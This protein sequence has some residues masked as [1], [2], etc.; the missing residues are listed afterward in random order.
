MDAERQRG[1]AVSRIAAAISEPARASMLY[2]LMDNRARTSTELAVIASVSPS[3]ASAHLNRLKA[4]RLLKLEVQGRHRYYR[5]ANL[6]VAAVLEGMLVLAGGSRTPFEPTTPDRLRQARTCY[7]HLAG[8]LGVSL[9][10][11]LIALGWFTTAGNAYSLTPCGAQGVREMGID[12]DE[13]LIL[14]RRF[15]VGCLDWSER[16]PHLGGALGAALLQLAL[17]RK[18]VV[19]DLEGRA[20]SVTIRGKREFAARFLIAGTTPGSPS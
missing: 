2:A 6:D 19:Q 10:D 15:A 13:T 7:D 5:L 18:W 1:N 14:R 3:T 8:A 9:H 17:Q 16:R 12:L 20:L 11:R 4:E